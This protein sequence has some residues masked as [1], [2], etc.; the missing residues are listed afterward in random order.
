MKNIIE[1]TT[2]KFP[3]TANDREAIN[4]LSDNAQMVFDYLERLS[5]INNKAKW[6]ID[7]AE[8]ATHIGITSDEFRA[9][10]NEI[11]SQHYF[12]YRRP[13]D[14]LFGNSRIVF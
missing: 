3:Q 10:I 1:I 6:S 12:M 2:V 7:V 9:A 14:Y 5:T 11:Y 4:H 8:E 13:T